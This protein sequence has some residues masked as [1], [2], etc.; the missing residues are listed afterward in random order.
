MRTLFAEHKREIYDRYG[1][2]GLTGAGKWNL[3]LL[4]WVE[5]GQ[6]VGQEVLGKQADSHFCFGEGL[7]GFWLM[8]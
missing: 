5:V 2:E 3:G 1:R 7:G 8:A 4:R 6:G